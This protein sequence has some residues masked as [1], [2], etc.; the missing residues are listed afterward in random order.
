MALLVLISPNFV[1]GLWDGKLDIHRLAQDIH[2]R[3]TQIRSLFRETTD[4]ERL[5]TAIISQESGGNPNLLNASGSGAMGLGQ[6][7]P[8]NLPEWSR[9]AL[10]REITRQEFLSSSELQL[11][12]ID[13]KLNEYW[14]TAIVQSNGNIDEAVMRVAAWWYSGNPH[15]FTD[16]APQSWNGHAYP[17]IAEYS[18]QVLD[19]YLKR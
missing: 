1:L 4:L 19:R 3:A 10:G 8:E 6:I 11:Q 2:D 13:Y 7:M 16:T 15:K 18:Q 17:S 9:Q 12:I 5:R 14:Q